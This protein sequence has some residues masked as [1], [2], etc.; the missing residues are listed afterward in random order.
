MDKNEITLGLE[1]LKREVEKERQ[2]K[3]IVIQHPVAQEQTRLMNSW[4]AHCNLN[5][6]KL[7]CPICG[8]DPHK[9]MWICCNISAEN[10]IEHLRLE[11][12]TG[13][14]SRALGEIW[15]QA[16]KQVEGKVK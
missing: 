11:L 3:D 14:S 5:L 15:E 10:S 7:T 16:N 4:I 2:A 1:K 6:E 8:A 13:A 12:E 9:L